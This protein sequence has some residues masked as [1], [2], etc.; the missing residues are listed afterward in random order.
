MEAGPPKVR[1][2]WRAGIADA[3]A[4]PRLLQSARLVE[5]GFRGRVPAVSVVR[6]SAVAA[7]WPI[8]LRE[9]FV[10]FFRGLAFRVRVPGICRDITKHAGRA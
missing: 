10:S 3:P 7:P 9:P 2:S 1:P 4:A 8:L 6:A 5:H